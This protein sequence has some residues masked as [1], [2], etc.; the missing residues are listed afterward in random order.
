V[1]EIQNLT[2][3][4]GDFVAV[5]NVTT[6]IRPGEIVGLLGHNGAGKT[7]MMKM[8]TGYLDPSTGS[9]AVNGLDA[10][11][12]RQ[13][14]QQLIGYLP[15]NAPTWGEMLV[16]EYLSTMAEL[17]GVPQGQTRAAVVDAARATDLLG[18]LTQPIATLSKGLRQRVGIA[19]AIVHK[20]SVLILDEPTNGL[21]PAQIQGIRKLI[22][23]LGKYTTILLS[24]HILQEVEAVCSRVLVLIGGQLVADAPI[25][26]LTGS[27][28]VRL[29]LQG[30][31]TPEGLSK[32][33]NGVE[34][35]ERLG[36]DPRLAGY[37]QWRVHCAD[38]SWP[39][40]EILQVAQK[41]GWQV[42]SVAPETRTLE[43]V[44][45]QLE[46]EHIVRREGKV[47]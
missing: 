20:P 22:Q 33:V 5:D 27:S 32:L 34:R 12:D 13:K 29:S 16:Q 39:I 38:G 42:G 3:K 18:R 25:A 43:Q 15:E 44:F 37:T 46:R 21:D 40:P 6:S 14:L 7:T 35:V 36:V 8:L 11:R 9:V 24:T 4:Y 28:S 10:V 1:I 45:Q 26:Q 41:N 30:D 47:A 31:N 19:Q 17:R 23:E 2:R